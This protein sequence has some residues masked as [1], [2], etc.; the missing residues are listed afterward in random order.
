MVTP[1]LHRIEDCGYHH[2]AS[3]LETEEARPVRPGAIRIRRGMLTAALLSAIWHSDNDERRNLVLADDRL[4]GKPW[5]DGLGEVQG[6]H[7]VATTAG[8]RTEYRLYGDAQGNPRVAVPDGCDVIRADTLEYRLR[9][10]A[11]N[12]EVRETGF[13]T[14]HHFALGSGDDS[15]GSDNVVL[16]LAPDNGTEAEPMA[17]RAAE[18]CYRPDADQR[19]D[20]GAFEEFYLKALIRRC[21]AELCTPAEALRRLARDAAVRLLQNGVP[22]GGAVTIRIARGHDFTDHTVDVMVDDPGDPDAD[23]GM[24]VLVD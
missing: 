24:P 21:R 1:A 20:C 22:P 11:A 12:G 18:T 7:L 2:H 16:A 19:G 4:A 3:H 8:E 14:T 15:T 17:S 13:P 10:R 6:V 9:I 23:T 5:Y